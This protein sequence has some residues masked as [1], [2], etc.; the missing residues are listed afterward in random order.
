MNRL[1]AIIGPTAAG[2]SAAA[3]EVASA[4]NGEVINADSRLFYRGFDIGTAKPS[5]GERRG[6]PHHLIDM[7]RPEEGFSLAA[8]LNVARKTISD[9]TERGHL[10]VLVGGA[11]QYV[12]GLLEG[13]EVPY[14]PPD[15]VLRERLEREAEQEGAASLLARLQRLDP[16]AA[17]RVDPLNIRRV[18]RAI[19]RAEASEGTVG[20]PRKA[21]HPP[22]NNLTIGLDMDRKVLHARADS[23]IDEMIQSGWADEVRRLL[24]S[25]VPPDARAMYSIGYREMVEHVQG[26]L[27]IEEVAR[28]ARVATHR[29][30]RHQNNWFK[31]TD[32]RIKWIEGGGQAGE[33]AKSLVKQWLQQTT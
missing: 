15:P 26:Q 24:S 22:Y 3:V 31:Q 2:K 29:L 4:F 23:R 20:P 11:G 28:R 12:W 30:I 16:A 6:I 10:P 1:V 8:F 7:L 27:S 5:T 17:E 25:G 21:A 18:I 9:V 13:W 14:V 19:E 33:R 32:P